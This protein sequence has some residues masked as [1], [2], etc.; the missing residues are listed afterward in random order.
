MFFITVGS[1][2]VRFSNV[3]QTG[4]GTAVTNVVSIILTDPTSPR[5]PTALALKQRIPQPLSSPPSWQ[6]C[7][8][9][10]VAGGIDGYILHRTD[11]TCRKNNV[12]SVFPTCSTLLP[13]QPSI[14]ICGRWWYCLGRKQVQH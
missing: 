14:R 7:D 11:G 6:H 8:K 5:T 3:F 2:R 12:V 10:R 9:R 1:V 13:R 4:N